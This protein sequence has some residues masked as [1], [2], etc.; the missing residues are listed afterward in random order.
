MAESWG[1]M[2][3]STGEG[4]RRRLVVWKPSRGCKVG[5]CREC[6]RLGCVHACTRRSVLGS[7]LTA[8]YTHRALGREI[9]CFEHLY[10]RRH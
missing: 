4:G 7:R 6:C 2:H 5:A 8:T 9:V 10:F 3:E 1:L